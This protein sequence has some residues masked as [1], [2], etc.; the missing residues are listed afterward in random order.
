MVELEE[1]SAEQRKEPFRLMWTLLSKVFVSHA[2]LRPVHE[3]QLA[4][5]LLDL[6]RTSPLLLCAGTEDTVFR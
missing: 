1:V 2:E 6:P 5:L 4:C 3:Y